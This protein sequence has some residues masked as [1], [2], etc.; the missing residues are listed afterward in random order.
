MNSVIKC[1]GVLSKSFEDT[2]MGVTGSIFC[3]FGRWRTK[4]LVPL[5]AGLKERPWV[6]GSGC[7]KNEFETCALI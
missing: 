4:K 2:N 7:V 6:S 5:S 1:A 3:V